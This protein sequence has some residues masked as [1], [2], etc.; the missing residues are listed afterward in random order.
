[1]HE[2]GKNVMGM[3]KESML[4]EFFEPGHHLLNFTWGQITEASNE[5][6]KGGESIG[7][8]PQGSRRDI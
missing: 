7:H 1:M 2:G 5:Q 3:G 8:G 6:E 4:W